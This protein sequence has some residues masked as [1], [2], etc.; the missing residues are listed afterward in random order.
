MASEKFLQLL[1]SLLEGTR[2]GRLRWS[3]TASEHAF[4][5]AF[6]TGLVRVETRYDDYAEHDNYFALLQDR[7]GRTVDELAS[8]D[9]TAPQGFLRDLYNAARYSALEADKIIEK[10]LMDAERGKTVKPPDENLGETRR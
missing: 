3:E 2:E 5:V 1:T 10:M 7:Q 6:E 8:F 4:R 9:K